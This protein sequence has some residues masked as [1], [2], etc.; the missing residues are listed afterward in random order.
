MSHRYHYVNKKMNVEKKI[1]SMSLNVERQ[2]RFGRE[3]SMK[4]FSL[5][6]VYM[7]FKL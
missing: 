7:Y 1:N 5:V 2:L 6:F 3:K 4:H